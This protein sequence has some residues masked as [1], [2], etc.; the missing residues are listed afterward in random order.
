MIAIL[1][2]L[3]SSCAA[4]SE[5]FLAAPMGLAAPKFETILIPEPA[6]ILSIGRR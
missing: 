4:I 2:S 5:I 3:Q 6:Q 1:R